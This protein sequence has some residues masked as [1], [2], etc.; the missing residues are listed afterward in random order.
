MPRTQL[1]T[2]LPLASTPPLLGWEEFWLDGK[3]FLKTARAAHAKRRQ[4]FT[5]EILY[6]LIAMAVEKFVMAALMWHGIMPDNHTMK[7]LVEAME[8]TFPGVLGPL[9]G[10]LLKLD[11]FQQICDLEGFSISPPAM[12]KI[13]AMLELASQLETLVSRLMWI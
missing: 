4:V 11:A 5:T 12:E 3:A 9:G 6:N 1:A 13:P 2:M 8:A 10:N 7:D